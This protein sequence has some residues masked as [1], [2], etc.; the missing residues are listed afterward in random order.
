M[1]A[2]PDRNRDTEGHDKRGH[3]HV[4]SSLNAASDNMLEFLMVKS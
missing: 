1:S 4:H 3:S 2:C